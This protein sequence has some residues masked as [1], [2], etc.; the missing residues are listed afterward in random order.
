MISKQEIKKVVELKI[1]QLG[2]YLVDI[3]VNTANVI[4]VYIDRVE[5]VLVEHCLEISKKLQTIEGWV[6]NEFFEL[7]KFNIHLENM[8]K[9]GYIKRDD[10]KNLVPTKI[11]LQARKNLESIFHKEFKQL[12]S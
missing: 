11:A 2:G 5:G 7:D 6:Y 9:E 8:V 10:L 1:K 4:T 12:V 3:K